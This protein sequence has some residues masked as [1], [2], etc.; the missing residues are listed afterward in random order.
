MI[1]PCERQW[2]QAL[3]C[4]QSCTAVCNGRLQNQA[5]IPCLGRELTK[6]QR[7]GVWG[8][9]KH[10]FTAYKVKTPKLPLKLPLRKRL[11]LLH[12]KL[13]ADEPN[14]ITECIK[15]SLTTSEPKSPDVQMCPGSS[16]VSQ[17]PR[18][19]SLCACAHTQSH[20]HTHTHTAGGLEGSVVSSESV[21]SQDTA[22]FIS[23][24]TGSEES[25]RMFILSSEA[26]EGERRTF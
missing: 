15:S 9:K 7:S 16:K 13:C 23:D 8:E 6:G 25:T 26:P 14:I 12:M 10:Y 24:L 21:M 22:A 17:F 11:H 4:A 1:R 2:Y 3:T 18:F 19:S 5:R 20:R